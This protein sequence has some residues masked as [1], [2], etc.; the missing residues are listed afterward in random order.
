A[1]EDRIRASDALVA[2]LSG[3]TTQAGLH[4][5]VSAQ[6]DFAAVLDRLRGAA[7]EDMP[8]PKT[9]RGKLRPYQSRGFAWLSTM[10]ELGLGACLA[11]DMGLGKTIQLLAFLLERRRRA[12]RD[13]R[14]A[15]LVAP[16]S[17]L[18]NW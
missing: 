3:E 4:V 17:V 13:R 12:P 10:A 5:A 16:T 8:S 14:P 15:L 18:G 7:R 6:G 2:A 11:D 1:G 9:L